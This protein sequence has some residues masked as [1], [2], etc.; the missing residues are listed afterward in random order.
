MSAQ[1]ETVNLV[2]GYGSFLVSLATHPSLKRTFTNYFVYRAQP[3][4]QSSNLVRTRYRLKTVKQQFVSIR[5]S[6]EELNLL[7]ATQLLLL[8]RGNSVIATTEFQPGDVILDITPLTE[9]PWENKY[10]I[11]TLTAPISMS[12]S[13]P[14]EV[15]RS[16][17]ETTTPAS[18]NCYA[19]SLATPHHVSPMALLA[20][21][22]EDIGKQPFSATATATATAVSAPCTA[23]AAAAAVAAATTSTTVAAAAAAAEETYVTSLLA[24][25]TENSWTS[26]SSAMD[27]T[28]ATYSALPKI[29]ST[30]AQD[31][32][33]SFLTPPPPPPPSPVPGPSGFRPY[34]T[35]NSLPEFNSV[36]NGLS[37]LPVAAT[38]TASY[39]LELP[40]SNVYYD[41]ANFLQQVWPS[42]NE[43]E[44]KR[45]LGEPLANI[46]IPPPDNYA[47]Q[48]VLSL[49]E[50]A[51]SLSVKALTKRI[52]RLQSLLFDVMKKI[53]SPPP[54]SR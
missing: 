33:W 1:G 12:S 47:K 13:P 21:A 48:E 29:M 52:D 43:D 23:V 2:I 18:S 22:A 40:H 32:M 49:G 36:F 16:R 17:S 46:T 42:T 5:N 44:R 53:N 8:V 51:G 50:S 39:P 34:S 14:P 7:L 9:E 26:S 28:M 10:N 15:K 38:P 37:Q 4:P 31:K 25:P 54:V 24:T 20:Q 41:L 45:S 19:S 3:Q 27:T 11:G 30:G 6:I 35:S